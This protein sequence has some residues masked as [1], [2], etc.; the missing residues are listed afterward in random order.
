MR[1]RNLPGQSLVEVL[2]SITLITFIAVNLLSLLTNRLQIMTLTRKSIKAMALAEEGLEATRIIRD[3][4]WNLMASGTHGLALSNGA[5]GFQGASDLTEDFTR[6]VTISNSALNEK[7][8]NVAVAWT[9]PSGEI[10]NY[11]L[12]TL[13]TNWRS[14]GGPLLSGNWQNP[15]TLGSIDIGPGNAG[16]GLAVSN[17]KVYMSAKAAD[18]KKDDLYVIDVSNGSAPSIVGTV[19]TGPGANSVAVS[20]TRAYLASSDSAAQLQ[21]VD[22]TGGPVLLNS[23]KLTGNSSQAMSVATAGNLAYIGTAGDAGPEFF[24]VDVSNGSDPQLRGS[25]EISGDVNDL[26]FFNGHVFI[27]TSNDSQELVEIDVT[28]PASPSIVATIN[29]PGTGDAKSLF[30]NAQDYRAYIGRLVEN[31]SNTPELVVLNLRQ[32]GAPV[33]IGSKEFSQSMYA[34]YAADS[35]GF[36]GLEEANLEFQI[37]NVSDLS[38]I[39]YFSGLNFPQ[40]LVDFA[41]ENNS[42]FASVRSNDAL[43]II[44]SQ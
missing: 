25:L 38:N 7:T 4:G 9:S 39:T 2:I 18:K 30:I 31:G 40:S 42:V 10:T 15:Q 11:S 6:T 20:G 28:D 8:I 3:A 32:Q 36:F 26:A 22:I 13:L 27:A 17:S 34:V 29:M 19:N 23:F 16:T 21:I 1:S 12:D 44:T 14:I 41:F 37:F 24:I 43:R 33:L 35:L 5:W